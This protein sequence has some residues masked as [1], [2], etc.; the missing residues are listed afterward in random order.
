MMKRLLQAFRSAGRLDLFLITA[1][2]CVLLVLYLNGGGGAGDASS[3]ARMEKILSEIDGA[4]RVSVMIAG[5]GGALR[6]A[7]VAAEGADDMRVYLELL[8]AVRALTGLE[9]N[10]IEIIKS[11]G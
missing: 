10:C 6:G 3:E 4:G 9:T 11:S 2:I 5:E 1:M 8:R 7:V